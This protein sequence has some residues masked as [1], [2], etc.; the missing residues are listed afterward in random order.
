MPFTEDV[1]D[2]FTELRMN[3][4]KQWFDENRE[5]YE[6]SV[7]EASREFVVSLGD[8]LHAL[9][10][11]FNAIPKVNQSMFRVNRDVRFSKNK[12]PYKTHLG[13]L[14]WEGDR[15]RM[16]NSGVYVNIEAE[17]CF[18]ATG[19][20]SFSKD[21]LE[22]YRNAILSKPKAKSLQL[23]LSRLEKKH[24]ISGE[25]Y[26]NVPRG[27]DKDYEFAELLKF[28]GIF[29]MQSFPDELVYSDDLFITI[30]DQMQDTL[31]LHKWFVEN[32]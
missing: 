10:E 17:S 32:V 28:K 22:S 7:V 26:K 6:N 16:E 5:R 19:L 14:F 30:V 29:V 8:K 1:F 20:H 21:V 25:T 11:G 15:K 27:F 4:S 3:N 31:E 18:I 2:F 24:T 23:I 12:S 9:S 13:L